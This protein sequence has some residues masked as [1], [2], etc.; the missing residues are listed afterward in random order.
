MEWNQL[1]SSEMEKAYKSTLAMIE[2]VDDSE[3]NW[4]PVTGNNWMTMGQLLK[5]IA[6]ACGMCFKGFVTG[7]WGMPEGMKVEDIKPEDMLP[8]AESL[9][10]VASVAEAK[11]LLTQ[12]RQIALDML[13]KVSEHELD[14]HA[15]SAPW[16]P[17]EIILG[18]RLLGMVN[19]LQSHKHQLFYYLKLQGKKVNTFDLWFE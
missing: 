3:L 1:L 10:T 15:V 13:A 9:P 17:R 12:D 2:K 5:H 16:D 7:D 14:T 18:Y 11:Q 19:H 4:K 8:P 6:D